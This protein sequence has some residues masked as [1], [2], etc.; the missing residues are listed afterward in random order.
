MQ[1]KARKEASNGNIEKATAHLINLA[2]HLLSIGES[3]LAQTVLI[4]AGNLKHDNQF[5][6]EGDKKIKY[7][8]MSPI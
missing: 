2:T 8:T 7:D 5:S 6:K 1:E 3:G 4:E